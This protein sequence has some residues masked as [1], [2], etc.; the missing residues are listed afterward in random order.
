MRLLETIR[1][2]GIAQDL[3]D[4]YSDLANL[5]LP[6]VLCRVPSTATAPLKANHSLAPWSFPDDELE[7][8]IMSRFTDWVAALGDPQIDPALNK[9]QWKT[10]L[11]DLI[12]DKVQSP[13]E[14]IYAEHSSRVKGEKTPCIFTPAEKPPL[15]LSGVPH[16]LKQDT[17]LTVHLGTYVLGPNKLDSGRNLEGGAA[18]FA[19]LDLHRA[20]FKAAQPPAVE[21][22]YGAVFSGT[23]VVLVQWV[24]GAGDGEMWMRHSGV[25]DV[26]G[27]R[28]SA[29]IVAL[30]IG[31]LLPSS[32]VPYPATNRQSRGF[33]SLYAVMQRSHKST[34]PRGNDGASGGGGNGGGD[35]NERRGGGGGDASEKGQKRPA[36]DSGRGHTPKRGRLGPSDAPLVGGNGLEASVKTRANVKFAGHAEHRDCIVYS[37]EEALELV[38]G[39]ANPRAHRTEGTTLTVEL[40]RQLDSQHPGSVWAGR[41]GADQIVLKRYYPA[42]FDKLA[43]ELGAYKRLGALRPRVV[44][45]HGVIAAPDLAWLAL[46]MEDAG[47]SVA[48]AGGWAEVPWPELR[49]LFRTLLAIH[50]AGIE[51]C[52]I[53][54]R[55]VLL[56]PSGG[57]SVADFGEA[58][59]NHR[60]VEGWNCPELLQFRREL[61]EG[62]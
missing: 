4:R 15:C 51:H 26:A 47:P 44:S 41:L 59:L 19:K 39:A 48:S 18:I 14:V 50:R 1:P 62:G 53:T 57:A 22:R 21:C 32:Q 3:P 58:Q 52:D 55:N 9:Y 54:P 17:A 2:L 31:M 60:C 56:R 33:R 7:S 16:E 35:A 40:T 28:P 46:L 30:L 45:C 10:I 11:S 13:G 34:P 23:H 20:A 29:S 27:A 42:Q 24:A 36:T 6:L 5:R 43:R 37:V 25:L 49:L 8:E 61:G 12:S 38:T